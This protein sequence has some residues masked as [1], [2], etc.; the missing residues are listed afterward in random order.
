MGKIPLGGRRQKKI[1]V[2]S[3]GSQLES[4]HCTAVASG[5]F[6]D[7]EVEP[8]LPDY[9][10]LTAL[11][12][13]VSVPA[14]APIGELSSIVQLEAEGSLENGKSF[15]RKV[16]IPVTW[17]VTSRI[18]ASPV[19]VFF[20][21]GSVGYESVKTV[22]VASDDEKAFK[23]T[24][25]DNDNPVVRVAYNLNTEATCHVLKILAKP[26]TE[27]PFH[28]EIRVHTDQSDVQSL[29]FKVGGYAREATQ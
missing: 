28:S 24:Q 27:G 17:T 22:V 21:E 5:T 16:K 15:E 20:P 14:N 13:A 8:S 11:K 23:L 4:I 29:T 18:R 12:L 19:T 26:R 1:Q 3:G 10:H 7:C 6:V 25:I 2:L 9:P